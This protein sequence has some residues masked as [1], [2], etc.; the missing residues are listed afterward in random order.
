LANLLVKMKE[1]VNTARQAS[2]T[3]LISDQLI[4]FDN[5][6]DRLVDQ[7]LLA[8]PPLERLADQPQKRGRIKQSPAKNLLD[9]FQVHKES[10]LG[11]MCDFK[12]PFFTDRRPN[13]YGDLERL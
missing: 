5:R 11:F 6:Y 7:G 12:V 13:I 8:K 1:A 3:C 4:A 9:E 10:V 2:L